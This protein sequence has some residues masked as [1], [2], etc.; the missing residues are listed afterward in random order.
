MHKMSSVLG[1]YVPGWIEV[2]ELLRKMEVMIDSEYRR[3][4]RSR[5]RPRDDVERDCCSGV[6][7][8]ILGIGIGVE[9]N[10][11]SAF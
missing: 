2:G 8:A 10:R 9:S 7:M 3:R 1:F 11:E 5:C 4:S 6:T